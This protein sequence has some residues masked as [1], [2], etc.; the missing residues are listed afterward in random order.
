MAH[1]GLVGDYEYIKGGSME[2]YTQ[3]ISLNADHSASYKEFNETK[4]EK[5]TRWGNGYV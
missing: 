1:A 2:T 3:E 4:T 5:F